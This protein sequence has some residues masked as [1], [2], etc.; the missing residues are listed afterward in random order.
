MSSRAL[1][2]YIPAQQGAGLR[3]AAP[4]VIIL[5]ASASFV[6]QAMELRDWLEQPAALPAPVVSERPPAGV[7]A[8]MTQLFGTPSGTGRPTEQRLWLR[9]SFVHSDPSRSS[10]LIVVENA[11][12]KRLYPGDE[13][14][15]GLMLAAIHPDH[16]LLKRA[17]RLQSLGLRRTTGESQP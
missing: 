13:I 2:S 17:D 4:A 1:H 15:P 5:A 9:A 12:P 14:E 3:W 16:V 10:A 7:S 8:A 6:W 11:R